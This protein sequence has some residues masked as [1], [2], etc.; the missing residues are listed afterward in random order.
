MLRPLMTEHVRLLRMEPVHR[1]LTLLWTLLHHYALLMG[2][3]HLLF[4]GGLVRRL[5]KDAR[6]SQ[7]HFRVK[8]INIRVERGVFTHLGY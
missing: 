4:Q 3:H 6:F 5:V 2:M 7:L 8:G 1:E